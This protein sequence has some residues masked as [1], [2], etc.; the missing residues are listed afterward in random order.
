MKHLWTELKDSNALHNR[1]L[2][3]VIERA[4]AA[5]VKEAALEGRFAELERTRLA[6]LAGEWLEVEKQRKDFEVVSVEEKRSLRVSGLEFSSRIDRMDRLVE[7]ERGHV[8]I[9]YKTGNRVTPKDWEAPRP[10]DPQV[11]LYAVAA[12]EE[13]SAVAFAKLRPGAM[14]FAGFAKTKDLMPRVNA[15]KNWPALLAEWK[16]EAE[17]LGAAFAAGDAAVDPKRDLKTCLRCDLQTLCRV[18]EKFNV[19]EEIE[20]EEGG[21]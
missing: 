2:V 17:S 15:A 8:L 5:A 12:P 18:Y 21:E 1:N 20:D 9:D 19:L 11:P 7:G 13:L 16:N 4:A 3:P 10:D 6:K 14:R